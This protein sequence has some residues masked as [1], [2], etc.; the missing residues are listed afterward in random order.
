MPQFL[1]P[2]R[3]VLSLAA[4]IVLIAAA[5]TAWANSITISIGNIVPAGEIPEPASLLLLGVGLVGTAGVA[6]RKLKNRRQK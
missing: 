5:S 1:N 3:L 4:L 6:R 2:Q